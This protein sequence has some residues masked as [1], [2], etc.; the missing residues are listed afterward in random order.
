MSFAQNLKELREFFE[1]TQVEMGER[2]GMSGDT[3]NHF[4]TGRRIPS[5]GN[6]VKMKEGIGCTYDR[7]MIDK[8]STKA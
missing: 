3:I 2:C 7:L 4:E 6:I 1:L 5:Y 8:D